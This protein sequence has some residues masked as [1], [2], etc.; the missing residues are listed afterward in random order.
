VTTKGKA[1]NLRIRICGHPI[2]AS[3]EMGKLSLS[4]RGEN[5][6]D[7]LQK[8]GKKLEPGMVV[9]S[10]FMD[11]RVGGKFHIQMQN[12]EGEFFTAVGAEWST[13]SQSLPSV[14]VRMEMVSSPHYWGVRTR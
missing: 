1:P 6:L 3:N 10:T 2:K 8:Q 5:Y 12:R 4:V 9:P 13:T 11:S 14:M 7:T